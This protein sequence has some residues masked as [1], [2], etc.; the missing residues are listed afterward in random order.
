MARTLFALRSTLPIILLFLAVVPS[1]AAT[2]TW[3]NAAGTG[4]WSTPGNWSSSAVPGTADV[5]L[6]NA[7]S[8]ADCQV[9]LSVSVGGVSMAVGYTGS[10]V[11]QAGRTITVGSLG[12]TQA[13]G[14]F[15]GAEAAMTINAG[16]FQLLGGSFISTSG[17]FRIG[18]T[19]T[20]NAT[21]FAHTSGTFVHQ[22]GRVELAPYR[23]NC[24]ASTFTVDV[25]PSTV[26]H[27]VTL[28][29]SQS[30]S[31]TATLAMATGDS[32]KVLGELL[33]N[34]G[35][36]VGTFVSRGALVVGNSADGGEGQVVL[37]GTG[38]Q[39]Y[40]STTAGT[41]TG[42][43]VVA[44]PS[45]AV[46]PASGTTTLGVQG[47]QVRNGS[48][49]AP[50][51]TLTIGGTLPGSSVLFIHAGGSF[52]HN[53][54]TVEFDPYRSSCT[55][56]TFTLDPLPTTLFHDVVIN[57]THSCGVNA[58]VAVTAG[59]TLLVQR[60]LA[61]R[62]GLLSGLYRCGRDLRVGANADGGTGELILHGSAAQQ[63]HVE[64]PAGRTAVLVVDKAAGNVTP[65]ATTTNLRTQGYR[66]LR[67]GF[68]APTGVLAAGGNQPTNGTIFEHASGSF[69]H[70]GGTMLFDPDRSGCTQGSFMLDV[71]PTTQFQD[72]VLRGTHG[73]GLHAIFLTGTGDVIR[74]QRDL[75]HE[76]GLLNGAFSVGRDLLI[77]GA[78]DGGTGEISLNGTAAQLYHV[79]VASAR[80]CVVVVDKPTGAVGP[81]PGTT[82]FS[83]QGFRLMRGSFS[84]PTGT[85]A[86]GGTMQGNATLFQHVAGSFLH[87]SGTV[88][89]DPFRSSCTQTT[90]TMDVLPATWFHDLVLNGSH[91]CGLHAWLTT[92]TGDTL[93]AAHDLSHENGLLS[94]HYLCRND[95]WIGSSAD[96]GTGSI[97]LQGTA[98]QMYH[99][100]AAASRTCV[101]V[102]DKSAG[103]VT[104]GPTTTS[105][106]VQGIRLVRGDFTAPTGQM[107]VG[108]TFTANATLFQHQAGNFFANGGTVHFDP[109]RNNCTQTTFTMDV[110]PATWFH[111]VVLNGSHG[112]SLNAIMATATGDTIKALGDL[113]HE[114]G[115]LTGA[116]LTRADLHVGSSADGGAGSIILDGAADQAY[117]V[118]A[119][120]TRTCFLV[121]R[122]HAGAVV[123]GP[124]T[125]EFSVQ[126]YTQISGTFTAPSGTWYIGGTHTANATVFD[127]R[128]GDFFHHGGTVE[129]DPYR[130]NCTQTT[131]TLDVIATT[132]FHDLVLNAQ[133]GCS[134]S[135]LITTAPGDRVTAT[136]DLRLRD[137]AIQGRFSVRRDLYVEANTD[138]GIGSVQFD[139]PSADQRYWWAPNVPRS[140]Q[141]RVDKVA[142][143]V[144]PMGTDRARM[145]ALHLVRGTFRAPAEEMRIG[146]T[147]ATSAIILSYT[148]GVFEAGTG[149]T[150]IDPGTSACS[151]LDFTLQAKPKM[152]FH[153]LQLAGASSCG[154][155]RF[156]VP[157][158]DTLACSGDLL[159]ANGLFNT[160]HVSSRGAVTV[161]PTFDGGAGKL[162]FKGGVDQTFDL[163]GAAALFNGDVVLDKTSGRVSL[164][165]PC[166]LDQASAQQLRLLRGRL[167][168]S[169]TNLL[170][171]G[172]NV[173]ASGGS[174][175]S[176]V[177][178]P[179]RKVGNDAFT[180]PIGKNDSLYAPLSITAPSN[181]GHH[182]TA[183]YMAVDPEDAGYSTSAL[184]FGLDHVSRCE[185]WA[186]ERSGTSVVRVTLSWADRSCGV[187]QLPHLRV[188]GWNGSLWADHGNGGTTGT[189]TSGTVIS[190][191]TVSQFTAFTLASASAMNPLPVELLSFT[192]IARTDDVVL[193]WRT[194]SERNC[195][196][197]VVERTT[198][199]VDFEEVLRTPGAGN[200]TSMR[201]YEG[202]DRTP[203]SG[204]SYYRLKQVDLDGAVEYFDLV[205]VQFNAMKAVVYPNPTEGSEL[206]LR[207]AMP[208]AGP[209]SVELFDPA[210]R[211]VHAERIPWAEPGQVIDLCRG[212]QLE[213]G[214]YLLR[215]GSGGQ[216]VATTVVVTR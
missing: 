58:V 159:L 23:V 183:E 178:G 38:I 95:L 137:G 214:S 201:T 216:V 171:I 131:F 167:V 74:A 8:L 13:D 157:A 90:F 138:A 78:A 164:L 32:L 113:R 163:T 35:A 19:Y 86:I 136:R 108:G 105:L 49:T 48:F 53:S 44:K 197:F 177:Q 208:T 3:T 142:G 145:T 89:F 120:A 144:L 132:A 57:A 75:T 176:F 165:S 118:S 192:A 126:G 198:D 117:H 31:Q 102:V 10:L 98:A 84:A 203:L 107:D 11:Q 15:I 51:G 147:W 37:D 213:P 168:T 70:N 82:M 161:D 185:Y 115:Y 121:V 206:W 22:S 199:G 181:V 85:F 76:D 209:L 210:G 34:N 77:V 135:A 45:G 191:G 170:T 66:Q 187:D 93:K 180:F 204:L 154:A 143:S 42:V 153:H 62:D 43:L 194:A 193:E 174:A 184:A 169:A 124:T 175:S 212:R 16:V 152:L 100:S 122:K 148:A 149:L 36:L 9:N 52:V 50:T 4:L 27:Q 1:H 134:V 7:T 28:D 158:A 196:H 94:G 127:H 215:V 20:G 160:G 186:L 141:I 12:W 81:G 173:T 128:A 205:P 166:T 195:D 200:S 182:F 60:D 41:R 133:H 46:V 63:Y 17:T 116:F 83:V 109:Y 101:L 91:G 47:L 207:T 129:I 146:G 189:T 119:P 55:Q 59:D 71:L 18:G 73:C 67:G 172:D 65:G 150:V 156:L 39:V 24:T 97:I 61:H 188:A 202:L 29:A 87:N 80:T 162:V 140:C 111:S 33:H 64:E 30:C 6:F 88:L 21:I 72:V 139:D 211:S 114:N 69:V 125:T 5:A 14:K 123:P 103:A 190:A 130:N 25:V 56:A 96:G 151:A 179:M 68:T 79:S 104:P 110:L 40:T 2:I 112:C 106:A 99:A 54:G 155:V 26:F 92:A